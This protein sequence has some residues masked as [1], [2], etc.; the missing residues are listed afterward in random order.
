MHSALHTL[1][2]IGQRPFITATHADHHVSDPKV[3]NCVLP[4]GSC[5]QIRPAHTGHLYIAAGWGTHGSRTG[6]WCG[7][8]TSSQRQS[9]QAVL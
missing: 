3:Q 8:V 2:L 1:L 6:W 9:A 5:Q 4:V 7:R